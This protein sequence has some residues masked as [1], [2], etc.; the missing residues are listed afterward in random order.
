MA[1]N[2]TITPDKIIEP[3]NMTPDM[4]FILLKDGNVV[5]INSKEQFQQFVDEGLIQK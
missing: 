5:F 2:I 4:R 3:E 1:T